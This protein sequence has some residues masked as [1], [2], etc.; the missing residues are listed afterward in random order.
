MPRATHVNHTQHHHYPL[1]LSLL[2]QKSLHRISPVAMDHR[3]KP[4]HGSHKN[5]DYSLAFRFSAAAAGARLD[6]G[7]M[8]MLRLTRRGWRGDRAS[9]AAGHANVAATR[10]IRRRRPR[11]LRCGGG[12]IAASQ[13]G[14]LEPAFSF[15]T[16][17]EANGAATACC[18]RRHKMLGPAAS[19]TMAW[20]CWN[21]DSPCCDRPTGDGN[22]AGIMNL[23]CCN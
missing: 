7:A 17:G 12:Q 13:Y 16:T 3:S 22:F 21:R 10:R 2:S 15:A 20:R 14:S 23:F 4:S 8:P 18:I 9:C 6:R 11:E 1:V 5:E 19:T